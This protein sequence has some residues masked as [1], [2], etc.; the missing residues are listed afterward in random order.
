MLPAL[1]RLR[2]LFVGA[3]VGRGYLDETA[4]SLLS[5]E[6]VLPPDEVA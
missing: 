3:P 2:N 5:D 6:L 1:L 4:S